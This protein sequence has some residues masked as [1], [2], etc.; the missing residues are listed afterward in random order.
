MSLKESILLPPCPCVAGVRQSQGRRRR[1]ASTTLDN[2]V[3][4]DYTSTFSLVQSIQHA[5]YVQ[6][7]MCQL[8]FPSFSYMQT[9]PY[10]RDLA[11]Y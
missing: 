8:S 7:Q 6:E 3:S 9:S 11:H 2:F 5:S 4:I 1:I 10:L